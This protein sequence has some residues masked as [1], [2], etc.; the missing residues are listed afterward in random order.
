MQEEWKLNKKKSK[1]KINLII[2][3][4]SDRGIKIAIWIGEIERIFIQAV[5]E[6]EYIKH[7]SYIFFMVKYHIE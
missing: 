3:Q 1:T 4:K 6:L 7:N 5:I 2:F